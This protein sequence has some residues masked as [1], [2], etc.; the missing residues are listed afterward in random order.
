MENLVIVDNMV[1]EKC[2]QNLLNFFAS[3]GGTL[4]LCTDTRTDTFLC[5]ESQP[6]HIVDCASPT[7]LSCTLSI[8]LAT[9]MWALIVGIVPCRFLLVNTVL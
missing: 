5:S 1:S 9:I 6:S 3:V 8:F 7:L 2:R 4:G